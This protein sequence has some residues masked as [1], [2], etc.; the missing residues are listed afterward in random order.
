MTD[1]GSITHWFLSLQEGDR[2]AAERLWERFAHKL[3]NLA[4]LRLGQKA[5]QGS[6]EEDVVLSAFDSF[7]RAAEAGRFPRLE[8]RDGLWQLLV[9]ITLRKVYDQVQH[10]QR[11]KRGTGAVL[12]EAD[13]AGAAPKLDDIMSAGPTPA[14]AAE[15]SEQCQRLLGLL[16]DDELRNIALFKMEGYTAHE[17]ADKLGCARRTVQRRLNL[18][19]N[20][21][22]AERHA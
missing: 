2:D 8:D 20:L 5:R 18:I 22:E 9:T 12:R 17:I 14:L 4:R 7:C 10:A 6:D 3:I 13:L 16:D 11:Q 1:A 15:M 19:K 21:W